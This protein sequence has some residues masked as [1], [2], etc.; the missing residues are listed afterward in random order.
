MLELRVI[1]LS[2]FYF[3]K[4]NLDT[5]GWGSGGY[6][7]NNVV[8]LMDSYPNDDEINHIVVTPTGMAE[9]EIVL[10]IVA[11]EYADQNELPFELGNKSGTMRSFIVSVLGRE[12]GETDDLAQQIF[13]WFRNYRISINNYNEG[14]PPEVTPTV[15]GNIDA[16]NIKMVPVRVIGSPDVADRYRQEITFNVMAYFTEGSEISFPT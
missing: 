16:E 10:P 3:L 2:I 12:E 11:L 6:Y 7:Q 8:T 5:S 4:E 14:F 1:K 13:E 15:I 9:S